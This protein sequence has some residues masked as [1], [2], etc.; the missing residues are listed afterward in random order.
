[1]SSEDPLAEIES[2]KRQLRKMTA[3]WL[4]EGR[5]REDLLWLDVVSQLIQEY[6]SRIHFLEERIRTLEQDLSQKER[7]RSALKE[8]LDELVSLHQLSESI[9]SAMKPEQVVE[10]LVDV[11]GR[12]VEVHR[13]GVFLTDERGG[14]EALYPGGDTDGDLGEAARGMLEDGILD[15]VM[16]E[17]RPSVVPDMES[18]DEEMNFVIV[19]LVVRGRAIGVF[20]IHTNKHR[21]EFTPHEMMLLSLLANQAAIAIEHGRAYREL[22]ETHQKL[23]KSQAQLIYSSRMAAVGELAAAVAHE[24]NNPLQAMLGYVQLL[25]IQ[26]SIQG[27]AREYLETV[28]KEGERIAEV[29][30]ELLGLFRKEEV[31]KEVNINELISR[32]AILMRHSLLVDGIALELHLADDLP[33]VWGRTDQLQ[34][35]F[36]NIIDNA[37]KAM[38]DGGVL[39]V[40]SFR[41]GGG[42]YV[43]FTDT[44]VGIPE[45]IRERIFE[46]FFST[47]GGTGL[48]LSVAREILQEHKGSIE[49]YN[50]PGEGTTVLV[51][52]PARR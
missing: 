50:R 42:V 13:A 24:I 49:V 45:K 14:M 32:L 36:M 10:A 41:K 5:C 19:P 26:D 34:Q 29:V 31:P 48:G 51:R 27:E 47:W 16:R 8:S 35:V 30:R 22:Y 15:W 43:Q 1:M 37:R 2:L 6:E 20:L 23:R 18:T 11:A 25:L 17:G 39:E 3:K 40:K 44:G 33:P 28:L 4:G 52:L 21:E 46:P 7:D 38:P 12:V 9:R